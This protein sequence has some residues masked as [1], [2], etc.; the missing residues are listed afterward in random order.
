M[1]ASAKCCFDCVEF[2]ADKAG[3]NHDYI[4][5]FL[6]QRRQHISIGLG[7][8]AENTLQFG[9]RNGQRTIVRAGGKH[10]MVV[11][12]N[13]AGSEQYPAVQTVY[14]RGLVMQQLDTLSVEE[15]GRTEEQTRLGDLAEQVGL[16]QRRPLI[17]QAW[18]ITD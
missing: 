18:L 8:D 5:R 15:F 9:A 4:S 14:R 2:E 11:G 12:G 1:N 3:A 7:L 10:Q 16:G 13:G 17:G 6:Y